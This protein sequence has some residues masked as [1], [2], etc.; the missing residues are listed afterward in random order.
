MYT[1]PIVAPIF[2]AL[3]SASWGVEDGSTYEIPRDSGGQ[4]GIRDTDTPSFELH[5]AEDNS[6]GQC[7][8]IL[9]SFGYS[10]DSNSNTM[11][12]LRMVSVKMMLYIDHVP[13]K[14][15]PVSS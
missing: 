3:P 15:I 2:D 6:H 13:K 11:A 12:L 5:K 1:H 4:D 8:T 14:L 10:E 7:S 9:E